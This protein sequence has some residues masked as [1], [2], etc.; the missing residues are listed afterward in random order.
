MDRSQRAG[1]TGTV[2]TIPSGRCVESAV[3]SGF[4][5]GRNRTQKYNSIKVNEHNICVIKIIMFL[6]IP[7]KKYIKA[8]NVLR[9]NEPSRNYFIRYD[10][11][12]GRVHS[13]GVT[14]GFNSVR[15]SPMRQ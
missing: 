4:I 2:H 3:K 5:T 1:T 10:F 13:R 14:R 7:N 12:I 8:D 15:S 11:G 6:L 9:N